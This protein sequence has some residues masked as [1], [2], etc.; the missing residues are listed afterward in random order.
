MLLHLQLPLAL[1]ADGPHGRV[2]L[3]PAM[4]ELLIPLLADTHALAE[5]GG[6]AMWLLDVRGGGIRLLDVGDQGG[7]VRHVGHLAGGVGGLG[8]CEH[9]FVGAVLRGAAGW[10][11]CGEHLVVGH[12]LWRRRRV[13]R[14]VIA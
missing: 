11:F 5:A 2:L 3:A 14:L 12:G 8:D 1:D 10:G 9:G 13:E 7:G 6:Q 4:Q